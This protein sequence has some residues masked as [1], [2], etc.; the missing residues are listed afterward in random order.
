MGEWVLLDAEVDQSEDH[1]IVQ[2]AFVGPFLLGVVLAVR[3][4]VFAQFSHPPA[5]ELLREGE[6][7]ISGRLELE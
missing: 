3:E 5:G 2:V 6:E 4:D 1:L 7:T